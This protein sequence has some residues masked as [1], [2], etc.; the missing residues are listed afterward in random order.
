LA[1]KILWLK[2]TARRLALLNVKNL[3][4]LKLCRWFLCRLHC[5]IANKLICYFV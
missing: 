5:V 2:H 4:L 1:A 3:F